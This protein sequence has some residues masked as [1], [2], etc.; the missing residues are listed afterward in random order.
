MLVFILFIISFVFI[1][2]NG[3][4]YYLDVAINGVDNIDNINIEVEEPNI[5]EITDKKLEDGHLKLTIRSL[6]KGKTGI[7]IP[8]EENTY[9]YNAFYV[10][11]F[12]II[13]HNDFLGD[14]NGDWIILFSIIILILLV[15]I[16]LIKKYRES[17]RVS[18]YQY[19]NILYFGVIVFTI[20]F[21]VIQVFRINNS[22][23]ISGL[24]GTLLSSFH[25]A[26]LLFPIAIIVSILIIISNINS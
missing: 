22:A 3:N 1:L 19:K 7:D 11:S 15:I 16:M 24:I 10:H 2:I 6:N 4:K 26:V 23:G 9:Y 14:I 21:F 5:I 20:S 13:T 8:F 17:Y 12:G 25:L 18:P